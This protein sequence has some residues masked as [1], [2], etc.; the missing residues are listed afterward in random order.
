MNTE[1]FNY[2]LPKNLI[3]Q[4][5]T[6]PR[7]HSRLLILDKNT[8]NLKHKYFYD[9]IDFFKKGDVIVMNNSKVFPARLKGTKEK[10]G[11]TVE[12]FLH[13][14][15]KKA[16]WQCILGGK[17]LRPGLKIVID[18][19]LSCE[20]KKNNQDGTW[21]LEFDK[22]GEEMMEVVYEVGITP[23]PP[24]IKR[25]K[26]NERDR[27]RYQTVYASDKKKGSV[28]APTAG[29]HFTEELIKK[30]KKKGARFEY[31]TLHV[32]LGTFATVKVDNVKEHKM[33]AEWV[34]I[35]K[36]T[37][38]NIYKAKEEGRRV[39]A[40]GTTSVRSLEAMA[41]KFSI[42][43]FQHPDDL[44]SEQIKDFREDVDIFIYP[45]FKFKIV[46]AM[47]TNFHLPQSTL[48]MLISAFAGKD[49]VDNAYKQAIANKYKFF[50]Y[51]DAMLIV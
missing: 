38:E 14:H 20:I 8:G 31:I 2:D 39:I 48:L 50:S 24:Y 18:E 9:I 19:R 34:E 49:R 33:H 16:I 22:E 47:I 28:A 40:V 44:I 7:D 3:A 45:E 13:R 6:E 21:E 1:D 26:K 43:N 36:E 11:G 10:T 27:K 15:V 12:V 23:L 17:K 41:E 46:D 25:E 29:L 5:P 37:I 42:F 32:G 51:G 4:T 30:L 35:S